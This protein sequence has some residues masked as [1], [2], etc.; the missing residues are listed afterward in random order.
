MCLFRG[1]MFTGATWRLRHHQHGFLTKY[2]ISF[3]RPADLA[4]MKGARPGRVSGFKPGKDPL[5]PLEPGPVG[6]PRHRHKDSCQGPEGNLARG[7]DQGLAL[8]QSGVALE[9]ASA[10]ENRDGHL[11]ERV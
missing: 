7:G 11:V 5:K 1:G 9:S 8:K 3:R 10:R 6:V 4:A 2:G